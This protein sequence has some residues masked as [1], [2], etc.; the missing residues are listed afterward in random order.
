[1]SDKKDIIPI[2]DI[3]DIYGEEQ[4]IETYM[5]IKGYALAK[6]YQQVLIALPVARRLHAGQKRKGGEPYFI[7]PLKV[8]NT[9]IT[10][11]VDDDN[12]LAAALL[13]DVLEDCMDKL[14]LGGKELLSE[15]RVS[16]DVYHIITLLSKRSGIDEYELSLYFNEIK[17]DERALMIK[18][19]DRLHNSNTLYIFSPDKMKKYIKETNDFILP[20]ASYGI[21]HYP[22]YTNVISGLKNSIYSMNNAM[23]IMEERFETELQKKDEEIAKLK[24][25]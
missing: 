24:Q 8:C 14:P 22:E 6:N 9:L 7:H 2:D 23:R 10:H 3:Y 4:F 19:A 1:M 20:L 12:T 13:H 15:Y 18:L 5:F 16:A 17:R 21:N 11:G 25:K